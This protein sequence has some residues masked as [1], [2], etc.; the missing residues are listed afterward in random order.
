VPAINDNGFCLSESQAICAYLVGQYAK[1][2][3]LYPEE[4]QQRA[5][6]DQILYFDASVLFP[7]LKLY[8]NIFIFY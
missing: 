7:S 1:N 6:V 3:H 8:V 4:A 5:R 2:D